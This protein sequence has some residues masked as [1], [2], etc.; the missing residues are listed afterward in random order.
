MNDADLIHATLIGWPPRAPTVSIVPNHAAIEDSDYG[1]T[2]TATAA[3]VS[4]IRPVAPT[5]YE[6]ANP[7]WR[8]R[9]V[10]SAVEII[11]HFDSLD[12]VPSAAHNGVTAIYVDDVLL[13]TVNFPYPAARRYIKLVFT[14]AVSRTIEVVMPYSGSIAHAGMT[15][16]GT[17]TAP[18]S[19][20]GL[21]RAVF[22]GDSRTQ[23][24]SALGVNTMWPE[25]LCRAKGWQHINLASGSRTVVAADGTMAGNADPDIAFYCCDYNNRT[26]QTALA[27]FKQLYKDVITNFRAVMPTTRFYAITSNWI[28]AAQD[29]DTLKIADYRTAT[30]DALTELADANNILVDGLTLT[31]NSTASVPDGIHPN[32]AGNAEWAAALGAVASIP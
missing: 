28:G 27:T 3:A 10:T 24:F 19:R 7:G 25:I 18:S 15:M 5:F 26:L 16:N 20:L 30:A 32:D 13:R 11:L 31:T 9:F 23:G 21:P 1:G 2:I 12:L 14:S 8:R 17:P 6:Y 4:C 22:I 29:G